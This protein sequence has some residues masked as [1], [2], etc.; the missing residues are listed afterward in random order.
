MEATASP[1]D[2]E[3][4]N[5]TRSQHRQGT[6]LNDSEPAD[7]TGLSYQSINHFSSRQWQG[8]GK[9]ESNNRHCMAPASASGH[10]RPNWEASIFGEDNKSV[11]VGVCVWGGGGGFGMRPVWFARVFWGAELVLTEGHACAQQWLWLS[12]AQPLTARWHKRNAPAQCPA[13]A[14]RHGTKSRI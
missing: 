11:C 10:L 6:Q 4:C 2:L 7:V 3:R 14:A 9:Q 8:R 5:A 13:R 1:L 12:V